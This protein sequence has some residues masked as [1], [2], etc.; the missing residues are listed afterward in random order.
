MQFVVFVAHRKT[1]LKK[2]TAKKEETECSKGGGA[3]STVYC[4]CLDYHQKLAESSQKKDEN[5]YTA[6]AN[7]PQTNNH[8]QSSSYY[9]AVLVVEVLS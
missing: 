7:K 3:R 1:V 8:I 4:G 2:C 6:V 5:Q 9:F